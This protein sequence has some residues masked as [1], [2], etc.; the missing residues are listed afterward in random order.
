M[1]DQKLLELAA[2]A[3]GRCVIDNEN[4]NVQLDD[5][6]LWNPLLNDGDA[7][8]I[9]VKLKISIEFLRDGVRCN[10]RGT[11][12]IGETC[13]RCDSDYLAHATRRAIVRAAAS[14]G[15]QMK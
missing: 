2:K 12:K 1:T 4:Y 3:I 14:I 11:R 13:L 7:L 9:A 6:T 15:E 10:A 5:W 8:R